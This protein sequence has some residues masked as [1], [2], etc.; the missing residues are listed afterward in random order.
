MNM[1]K[2]KIFKS[3]LHILVS[4]EAVRNFFSCCKE[5]KGVSSFGK[6]FAPTA[7]ALT[8]LDIQGNPEKP[9]LSTRGLNH[10]LEHCFHKQM[11]MTRQIRSNKA[12]FLK[13][14]F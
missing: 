12:R 7:R 2:S 14:R 13:L 3:Q 10:N 6:I 9:A 11:L 1:A 8:C 4:A 5:V